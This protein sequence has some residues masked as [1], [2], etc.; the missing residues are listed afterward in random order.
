[1]L[2]FLAGALAAVC[3]AWLAITSYRRPQGVYVRSLLG[4]LAASGVVVALAFASSAF[5]SD[6]AG[7]CAFLIL[8][9]LLS[10]FAAVAVIACAAA[11]LRHL[12]DWLAAR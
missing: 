10:F 6:A 4:L 8:V 9:A 12:V 11:T 1:M 3:V 5:I 7:L 2:D